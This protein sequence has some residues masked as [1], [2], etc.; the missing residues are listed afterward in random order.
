MDEERKEQMEALVQGNEFMTHN[1]IRLES[2]EQDRAVVALEIHP[3]SKNPH[4]MVHGGALYTMADNATGIAVHTDGRAHVT[5][6]GQ[7]HFLANQ[8]EGTVRAI[9]W[10]RRR[11]RY[12]SLAEVDIVGDN[13]R[14]LATG[15]FSYFC[16]SEPRGGKAPEKA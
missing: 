12:T 14:L 8:A 2:V 16:I 11:G 10:V 3:E 9:G 15:Q 1:H 13:G 7:L 5:Q 6:N 4:N